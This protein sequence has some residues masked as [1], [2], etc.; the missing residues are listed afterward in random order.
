[1]ANYVS[2]VATPNVPAYAIVKA[3]V[4]SSTTITPGSLIALTQLDTGI[5]N[6][7]QVFVATKPATANLGVQMA[8]VINDGFETLAD[9]RRPAGQP[10]YTQYTY[11]AGDV[12]TCVLLVPGLVFE[13]SV[14]CVTS[15]S[16]LVAGD[17][18]EPVD[19]SYQGSRV[20]AG[21]GRTAGTMSGLQV[22]YAN[23]NFRLGGQ[24]GG[25]FATTVV[26]MAVPPKVSAGG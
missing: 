15:G 17:F 12:V 21:T 3:R 19:G 24:F 8:I 14:D 25:N 4:P 1:M 16:S 23:K 13:I 6:N 11:A 10:D 18:I 26:A 7:W 9:G 22:L 5:E 2:R 20:E